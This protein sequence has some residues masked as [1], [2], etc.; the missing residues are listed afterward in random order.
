LDIKSKF[1]GVAGYIT[2]YNI[3]E[4]STDI[5]RVLVDKSYPFNYETEDKIT[6]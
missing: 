3:Y 4:A 1:G 6:V 2:G 5:K